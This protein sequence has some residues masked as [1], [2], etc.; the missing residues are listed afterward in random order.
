MNFDISKALETIQGWINELITLLPNIII[1]II[2]FAVIF[3]F[4]KGVRGL[5]IKLTEKHKRSQNVGIVVGRLGF[6]VTVILGFFIALMIIVPS[7]TAGQLIGALGISS[8]AIG[9]AFKDI[10]QNFLAGILI[11]MTDSFTIGDQIM[12]DSYEGTVEDIQTRATTI[13]TY[14]NR[15]VVIPNSNMFTDSVTVNTAYANRRSQYDFGIAFSDDIDKAKGI[16]LQVMGRT[17]GVLQTPAPD[18]LTVELGDSSVNIRGRW[19]TNPTIAE[20]L[21]VQ[22]RVV[23]EIKKEFDKAGIT[24]PFPIRTVYFNDE[25]ETKERSDESVG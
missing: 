19:W 5:I 12:V 22:D 3:F 6:G 21:S 7:F 25:R 17:E 1:A 10:L 13:R 14:D 15:K 16:M 8:I 23:S 18:V 24:I 11:L 2:A 9:F 20:V 4:G